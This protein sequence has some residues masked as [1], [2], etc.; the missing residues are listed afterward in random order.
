MTLL[1][2]DIGI[3]YFMCIKPLCAYRNIEELK[4]RDIVYLFKI[5]QPPP[6]PRSLPPCNSQECVVSL[7]HILTHYRD[8][9][10]S[11]VF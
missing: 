11:R 7:L 8:F 4:L 5:A 6:A 2:L 10:N 9:R 1:D 3:K